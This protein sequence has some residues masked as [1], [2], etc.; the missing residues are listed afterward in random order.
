MIKVKVVNAEWLD[1]TKSILCKVEGDLKKINNRE[2]VTIE[3]EA[4]GLN[5][6][7]LSYEQEKKL[8]KL[9]KALVGK[10]INIDSI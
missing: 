7:S 8:K 3:P 9:A 5:S 1:E 4:F 6:K 2:I 10:S